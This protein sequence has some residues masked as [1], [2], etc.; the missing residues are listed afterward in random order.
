VISTPSDLA[1]FAVALFQD[2]LLNETSL[3]EMRSFQPL[4]I[5]GYSYDYGLGLMRFNI[6]G[7]EHWAHSGG[8]FGEYAWF[9]YCPSTK[10][11]L[12]VAYNY[13]PTKTGPRLPDE[14][15]IVL[16]GLSVEANL[17]S[18][19]YTELPSPVR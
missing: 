17:I 15:L 13:P 19:P 12:A 2:G 11:S 4:D 1:R 16:S 3:T 14:L 18:S 9:F 8:L 10:I 5:V 7:R 6:L